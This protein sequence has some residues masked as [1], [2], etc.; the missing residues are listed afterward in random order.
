MK[1]PHLPRHKTHAVR[2]AGLLVMG[3]LGVVIA[4]G[5]L[6]A[7]AGANRALAQR[8]SRTITGDIGIIGN[9]CMTCSSST[10]CASAQSGSDLVPRRNNDYFMNPV[11]VDGVFGAAN[12]SRATLSLPPGS[13]VL[14]AG[15]YWGARSTS[16][17]RN[18]ISFDTPATS[19]YQSLTASVLDSRPSFE[20]EYQGFRDVTGLVQAGGNGTYTAADVQLTTGSDE[21]AG[22]ALVVAY[23]DAT[24]PTRSLSVFD[25]FTEVSPSNPNVAIAL[26]GFKAPS[27]GPV[28]T[29]LG[30]VA[31]DGDRGDTGDQLRLGA[32]VLSDAANPGDDFFNSTISRNGAQIAAKSPS[33]VNQ[34]GLDADVVD[35]SGVLPNGA[36]QATINLASGGETFLPGV[37]TF[38]SELYAPQIT[39]DKT[40]SDLNGGA[41]EQGDVIEYTI[42]GRNTGQDA[43]VNLRMTDAIP[44]GTTYVPGSLV[45]VSGAPTPL[46]A[47]SD[48]AGDDSAEF[49]AADN[50]VVF[51]LGTGASTT[52]GGELVPNATFSLRF[53][54]RVNADLAPGFTLANQASF[55]FTGKDTG[56]PLVGS[57]P[58]PTPTPVLSPDFAL[59]KTHTGEAVR[60]G[61]LTYTLVARNVGD[62]ASTGAVIVSDTLPA[63]LTTTGPPSGAGWTCGQSGQT[64]SCTR[65]DPLTAGASYAA[66]GVP[67]RVA[68]DAPATLSNAASVDGAGD[69]NPANDAAVDQLS[70]G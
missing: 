50:R 49:S 22:W 20:G 44:P 12:S 65:S 52:A 4:L 24:Q 68:Q 26:S 70:I 11:D 30:A 2:R 3:F 18:Q 31:Y 1:R 10:S 29:A 27:F 8:Y 61:T 7:P 19:G 45:E 39:A 46:G 48:A 47:R 28:R 64:I 25:G 13:T 69:G 32:T 63:G 62:A 42:S 16:F 23:R 37:V 53:R 21:Y 56:E 33:Y 60:G 9:T 35:A 14:F 59:T 67:V 41:V 55:A 58:P 51:R 6:C 54:V 38:S 34:L 40:L 36:T 17:F 43:A 15:L 57:S 5:S 66:I